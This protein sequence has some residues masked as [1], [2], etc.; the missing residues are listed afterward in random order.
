MRI[1]QSVNPPQSS[2][3]LSGRILN[4]MITGGLIKY[5]KAGGIDQTPISEEHDE[6]STVCAYACCNTRS[7]SRPLKKLFR[8]AGQGNDQPAILPAED[9]PVLRR[10]TSIRTTPMLTVYIT[11]TILRTAR[12]ASV[13]VGVQTQPRCNRDR[14]YI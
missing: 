5:R 6:K 14:H 1:W 9:V 12:K 11:P 8:P 3:G 13:W 7:L 2:C 4:V 10:V